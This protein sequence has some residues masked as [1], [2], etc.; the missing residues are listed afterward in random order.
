MSKTRS[1]EK[2]YCLVSFMNTWSLALMLWLI[3]R[4]MKFVWVGIVTPRLR[5]MV[6]KV[7][8]IVWVIV[9]FTVLKNSLDYLKGLLERRY[10]DIFG[11]YTMIDNIKSEIQCLRDDTGVEFQRWYDKSKQLVSY[12]YIYIYIYRYWRGNAKG[13]V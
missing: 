8:C 6:W 4:L 12:I 1:V 11:A 9:G 2:H 10:I 3:Q 13:S 7:V 5:L